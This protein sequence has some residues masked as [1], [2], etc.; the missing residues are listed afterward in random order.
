MGNVPQGRKA[1]LKSLVGL[2]KKK[3]ESDKSETQEVSE[4]D[5]LFEKYSRK[6]LGNR[7][8]SPQMV[9]PNMDGTMQ[10]RVGNVTSGLAPYLGTWTAWEVMHLL[11][12]THFGVKKTTVDNFVTAGLSNAVNALLNVT[13][14]TIPSTKPLNYYQNIIT[15]T[16]DPIP[17][18]STWTSHKL[19]YNTSNNDGQVDYFRALSISL[20]QWG[21]MLDETTAPNIGEKMLQFWYHFIP[22]NFEAARNMEGNAGAYCNDYMQI[23]RSNALGNFKTL[24]KAVAKSPAMLVYLGGQYSTA[25]T[26]NENFARELLELFTM[27][28]VPTQNYT[29]ADVI[30][31][32]KI[33]SGWVAN[34]FYGYAAYP[35]I[36]FFNANLHN[37]DDKIFSSFF[38]NTTIANQPGPD[39]ANEFELFFDMLFTHQASTIAK[40][41]CRRLYR[42]FVYYDI[43]ANVEANVIAPL[44]TFLLSSNWEIAPVVAKLLKSEHFFDIVNRGVMIKSPVDYLSGLMRTLKISTTAAA[45]ADYVQK[46]YQ[47]WGNF[48][49]FSLNQFEQGLGSVPTVSGWKAYYQSPT[50]YQNWINSNTIQ[51]RSLYIDYIVNGYIDPIYTGGVLLKLNPIAFVQ[52]FPNATIQDPVLLIDAIVQYLFSNDLPVDFKTETKNQNLLSGQT[53]DY[54]W[55]AAW[56]NYTVSP[57]NMTYENIVTE[58]LK[59][60]FTSLLQLSEFQ[61]M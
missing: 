34:D 60:L 37:Q 23:L 30:A 51:Q 6:T 58:R 55:T 48:H 52:Q 21:I 12:R 1:F 50:F 32:S 19:Q 57:T 49:Y 15:P 22:V 2:N 44:A 5:P 9:M 61:L 38:G 10:A 54:Y 7:H 14:P 8:F 11:R 25:T 31:A 24:I 26:P 16:I 35:F 42:F 40:Y 43:D 13:A 33:F 46:Q 45:G 41:I 4:P 28:K 47:V 39:G 27:G 3:V 17:Y 59:A 20:W 18:G 36:T 29:E 53:S 56:N